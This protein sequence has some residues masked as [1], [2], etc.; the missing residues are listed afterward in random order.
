MFPNTQKTKQVFKPASCFHQFLCLERLPLCFGTLAFCVWNTY[1]RGL[2]V[3][4]AGL[5]KLALRENLKLISFI[6]CYLKFWIIL[7]FFDILCCKVFSILIFPGA[8]AF[9]PVMRILHMTFSH[10]NLYSCSI[11]YQRTLSMT[12]FNSP[13]LGICE[14]FSL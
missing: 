7:Y 4:Y 12:G 6:K 2:M 14:Q 3:T 10:C 9:L 13:S 8:I 1:P 5:K 11:K